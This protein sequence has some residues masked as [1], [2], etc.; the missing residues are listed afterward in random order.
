M[1]HKAEGRQR[2]INEVPAIEDL[3]W[4]RSPGEILP[5]QV[6]HDIGDR[7]VLVMKPVRAR[8]KVEVSMLIGNAVS[9][10]PASGLKD[11]IGH[12]VPLQVMP[13]EET[14][15]TAA[16]DGNMSRLPLSH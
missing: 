3:A 8:I 13:G 16:Q 15:G 2:E 7:P 14:G 11:G 10:Y 6:G 12:A 5:K 4:R 9:A 1:T